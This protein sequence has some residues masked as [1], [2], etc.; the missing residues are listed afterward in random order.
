MVIPDLIRKKN[1]LLLSCVTWEAKP[2]IGF[3]AKGVCYS[4]GARLILPWLE[5]DFCL[6]TID[7]STIHFHLHN[8]DMSLKERKILSRDKTHGKILTTDHGKHI[9]LMH[10]GSLAA[11]RIELGQD[12]TATNAPTALKSLVHYELWGFKRDRLMEVVALIIFQFY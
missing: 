10:F 2:R 6:S 9:H 7:G 11:S 4:W 3:K 5:S 12:A 8:F 1:L